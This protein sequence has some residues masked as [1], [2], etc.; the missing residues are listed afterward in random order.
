MSVQK[1]SRKQYI[2]E[3]KRIAKL[4]DT[5]VSREFFRQHAALPEKGIYK[6]FPRFVD[7]VNTAIPPKIEEKPEAAPKVEVTAA[8][9]LE[10]ESQKLAAKQDDKQKLL[11][12]ALKQIETLKE[13]KNAILDLTERTP[14][15]YDIPVQVP[16][17]NSESVAFMIASDWHSEEE[18]LEGQVGGLNQ[19]NLDIGMSR[20][21]NFWKG[22]HRMYDIFRR[23]T[24]IKTIVVG[25]LGDFITNSIHEDGAESN[26]LA[27]TDAIYRVQNMLL[28]GLR[29]LLQ[30]TDAEL[31]VVCHTG[32]HGRTTKE[33]RISTE[34]GN[35]L[36]HYMYCNMR[37]IMAN[38]ARVTF[39]IAEGYH[40]YVR[41]FDGKYTVRMHHGHGMNY[42]GGMGGITTAVNKAIAQWNKGIKADLDVFGHFHTSMDAQNFVA[43]GSLIGYNSYALRI[44]A[45]YEPPKQSFFLVN[46]KFN[47]KSVFTPI[48]V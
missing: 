21:N 16:S 10:L 35:S 23:D 39:Q 1:P 48:F 6:Y 18:V 38:E 13:E 25:L 17:G 27:P 33:Q 7:L 45:D 46:K 44:R 11:T 5:V 47:A 34:L 41:L 15:L 37:D 2:A 28:S 30:N 8:D 12:E 19:H 29:F 9:K 32:N 24:T 20:A 36:E 43:N 22:S 3:V 4:T 40:S 14:Q 42:G 31:L 26:L